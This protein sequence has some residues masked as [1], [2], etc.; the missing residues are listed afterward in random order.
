MSKVITIQLNMIDETTKFNRAQG[1]YKR[2]ALAG[3]TTG[4]FKQLVAFNKEADNLKNLIN[5]KYGSGTMKYGSEIPQPPARPEVIEIDL[6]NDFMKRNPAADGGQMVKPSADGSRPGYQ[7]RGRPQIYANEAERY[8]ASKEGKKI[9][10][11]QEMGKVWDKK[12]KRFREKKPSLLELQEKTRKKTTKQNTFIKNFLK[13]NSTTKN[14]YKVLNL[15]L[16]DRTNYKQN[17]NTLFAKLV[18]GLKEKGKIDLTALNTLLEKTIKDQNFLSPKQYRK[19]IIVEVFMDDFAKNGQFT[20]QAKFDPRLKEFRG[21]NPDRVYGEMNRTFGEWANGKF[22]VD[23]FDRSKFDE[24]I[25]KNLKNWTPIDNVAE[26]SLQVAKELKFLNNLNDNK[27]NLSANEVEKLFNKEFKNNKYWKKT[28]FVNRVSQLYPHKIYGEGRNRDLITEN[29]KGE[30]SPW[31]RQVLKNKMSGNFTRVLVAADAAE[32][33]GD[34]QL[35]KK[36]RKAAKDLFMPGKGVIDK[37]AGQA[38]HPWFYNYGKGL[39]QIDSLVKG[40]LNSFKANNFEIPIRELIKKY[41]RNFDSLKTFEK[42]AIEAEIDLRRSFLNTI[43]D[44]GDG[45]MARNVTFDYKSNPGT[46]KV[47]N[48]TPDIYKQYL[49]DRLDPLELQTRGTSYR[50]TL[51][52]NLKEAD[53]NILKKGTDEIKTGKIGSKTMEN[54]IKS[55]GCPNAK[56]GGGRIDFAEG[57]GCFEKG[58]KLINEGFKGASPAAMKNGAKFLNTAYRYGRNIMKFGI[59]PEAIFV[60]GETLLRSLG[61][62]TLEEGLKSS[63][64]FYTDWTGL[65]NLKKDARISQNMRNMGVD[66]TM[67]IERLVNFNDATDKVNKLKQ[68]KESNLAINDESLTGLT[69][70]EVAANADKNIAKAQEYLDKN[71]LKEREKLY[72]SQQQDEAADI[73]GT[74][75]PFQKF[76]GE[77]KNKTE[78]MRYEPDF[79]GMQS[80]MLTIDPMSAKAKKDS[81]SSLPP[82]SPLTGSEGETAFL[83]LSQLPMGPRMGSEIDV[84]AKAL[85]GAGINTD[86]ASLKSIQDYKKY[87]K[88]LTIEEMLAMGVPREAILGFNQAEPIETK[89]PG[90]YSNYNPSDRYKNFKLGMFSEGGITTLRSKYEYKK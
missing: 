1:Y 83:K 22:E 8:A 25:K 34:L 39:F 6:I 61:N 54:L 66:A 16:G 71:F 59:I 88:N 4:A 5:Q 45:G 51:I 77:A 30:R 26:R 21:I 28:S 64:G 72:F 70:Q 67:N 14:G 11:A 19:Q 73:A 80:D 12:T 81:V 33:K 44:I 20:G 49:S 23:G 56:A 18:K 7:G 78:N 86:A 63:I 35:A 32:A 42:K 13:Q 31:L 17:P 41:E 46:I 38:E 62:Q 37:I 2:I 3:D 53:Y 52:K 50:D 10:E 43:T 89:G 15:N 87:F 57:A 74:K 29:W 84:L 68:M 90:Y 55:I 40:D 76:L 27:P 69:D 48:K 24:N 85:Q 79:T 65:T 82:R 75:S 36:Y 60:G 47:I 9:K 58:Q